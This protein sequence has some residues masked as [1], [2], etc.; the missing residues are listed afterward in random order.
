MEKLKFSLSAPEKYASRI[1]P[2]PLHA[3]RS[4]FMRDRDRIM[5]SKAFR[6]LAGKTQV[7]VVGFDDHVRNRLTHTLE[8]S[9]IA[10]TIAQRLKLD[11][12]LTEAIALGH[13]LGHT[14]FGHVGERTLNLIMNNCDPLTRD[15]LDIGKI[16]IDEDNSLSLFMDKNER[17]FKH[18]LQSV[19]VVVD[20]EL[21]IVKNETGGL[22][23]TNYTLFGIQAHSKLHWKDCGYNGS[24]NCY[25]FP[26]SSICD[27]D[28]KLE[29]GYYEKYQRYMTIN[30]SNKASWSF[31]A[32]A[33]AWADEIAQRH[34]D[35]EDAIEGKLLSRS[36]VIEVINKHFGK[37]FDEKR[38]KEFIIL[39]SLV[40]KSQ[41]VSRLSRFLVDFFVSSI[42][43]T[44]LKNMKRL[45]DKY[46]LKKRS[47]FIQIYS[48]IPVNEVEDIVSFI[49][50][51]NNNNNDL[52][53]AHDNFQKELRD[54]VLNSFSV[55]RM[56]G[57]A[58]YIIRRLF[59]AYLTNPQ[60]IPDKTIYALFREYRSG[61]Y[62]FFEQSQVKKM[63]SELATLKTFAT[64]EDIMLSGQ[65][66][67]DFRIALLRV[68]TV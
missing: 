20:L 4:A 9:Q 32:Y 51:S 26:K 25:F 57:K 59:K 27:N 31:E 60:Q 65:K 33:V 38:Q 1:V 12:H 16:P 62:T 37:V 30:S 17:G 6:R 55:H 22:N 2:E 39:K 29:L 48:E 56:D 19:R 66:M 36:E 67:S 54:I 18:N 61:K 24:G 8:V 43:E 23:L 45:I 44:T 7:F 50:L 41:F 11:E 58:S 14:P 15:H 34:H 28:N 46:D 52:W 42:I 3:Y 5:Y 47:D 40:H 49:E 64:N 13:D 53:I 10:R 68:L 21:P 35:I 63:R